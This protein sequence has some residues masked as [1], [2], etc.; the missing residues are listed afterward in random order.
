M[1]RPQKDPPPISKAGLYAEFEAATKPPFKFTKY[2]NASLEAIMRDEMATIGQRFLAWLMRRSWG[3]YRLFAVQEDGVTP[4]IQR[5]CCADLGIDKTSLSRTVAYYEKRGY[6]RCEGKLLIPVLVPDLETKPS[7]VENSEGF[8]TFLEEWKVANSA[9]FDELKVARATLKRLN[10]VVLSDYKKWRASRNNAGASLLEIDKTPKA[11]TPPKTAP[12]ASRRQPE[13][14]NKRE[15]PEPKKENSR[16]AT[17]TKPPDEVP[18]G[19]YASDRDELVALMKSTLGR[20]P[21]QKAVRTIT[22]AIELRSGCLREYLDDI[23]PRLDRLRNPAK[24]GFFIRHAQVWGGEATTPA[25][26]P[27]M[28]AKSAGPCE[29][30]GV[31]KIGD[32]Y[33]AC[34]MGVDLQRVESRPAKPATAPNG[35]P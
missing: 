3:E 18:A 17:T 14:I 34:P 30:R 26:D 6:I 7:A 5:N 32:T 27:A 4:A 10:K 19:G 1:P 15:E 2:S 21:D 24:E 20:T 25:P 9:D 12:P 8:A 35:V 31:G 13:A 33:C 23:R 16:K 11:E 22:E 28:A 29:C